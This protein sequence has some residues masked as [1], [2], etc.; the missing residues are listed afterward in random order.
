MTMRTREKSKAVLLHEVK[1]LSGQLELEKTKVATLRSI[2][3]RLENE[4]EEL[5]QRVNDLAGQML[6]YET[7]LESQ[8]SMERYLR[9]QLNDLLHQFTTTKE[10][11][12]AREQHLEKELDECKNYWYKSSDRVRELE[13]LLVYNGKAIGAL[14][15]LA[16]ERFTHDGLPF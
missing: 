2:K 16:G 11:A 12:Q 13:K 1:T 8:E 10:K 4:K 9:Q 5:R 14:S 15:D 3:T 7:S 6:G